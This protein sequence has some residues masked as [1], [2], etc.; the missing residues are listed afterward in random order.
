MQLGYKPRP[1]FCLWGRLQREGSVSRN[2]FL[3]Q[4]NASEQASI[5]KKQHSSPQE[6]NFVSSTSGSEGRHRPL[7]TNR[8]GHWATLLIFWRAKG[9]TSHNSQYVITSPTRF[10]SPDHQ[11]CDWMYLILTPKLLVSL[12]AFKDPV[13]TK[14]SS[15]V[16]IL[17]RNQQGIK[18]SLPFCCHTL[19]ALRS[20]DPSQAMELTSILCKQHQAPK[21]ILREHCLL[22]VR[23]TGQAAF[24]CGSLKP[25]GP[26]PQVPNGVGESTFL[27]GLFVRLSF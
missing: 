6:L 24:P 22:P 7:N 23:Q 14:F 8:L 25:G 26:C 17:K 1:P 2:Q 9:R 4:T 16:G 15:L 27:L 5:L 10:L 20:G 11:S 21:L 13:S 3:K 12:N 18:S 19:V